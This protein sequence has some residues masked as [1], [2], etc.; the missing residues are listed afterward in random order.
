MVIDWDVTYE[1]SRIVGVNGPASAALSVS[2]GRA[3]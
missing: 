3:V 2:T 1:F